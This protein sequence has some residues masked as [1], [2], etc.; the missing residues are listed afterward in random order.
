MYV[1][2]QDGLLWRT[3]RCPIP[4]SQRY[5]L[6]GV[7][8]AGPKPLPSAS[9]VIQRKVSSRGGIRRA[10]EQPRRDHP[11]QGPWQA[12]SQEERAGQ[13]RPAARAARKPGGAGG[14][15]VQGTDE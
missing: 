9:L 6:H 13:A 14:L 1:I 11:V 3:L 2:T 4:A 10:K 8:L 12:L 15:A 7:R 5:K